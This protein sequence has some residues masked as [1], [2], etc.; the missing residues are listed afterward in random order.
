[1]CSGR[2]ALRRTTD[3]CE[4]E[5][6]LRINL[7]LVG[8]GAVADLNAEVNQLL[9]RHFYDPRDGIGREDAPIHCASNGVSVQA[10]FVLTCCLGQ[11]WDEVS[12]R[13]YK[14]ARAD[15]Q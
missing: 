5:C 13:T 11:P 12:S 8:R 6:R 7:A 14:L 10:Y 2:T 9:I 4:C 3:E 15:V 1:M